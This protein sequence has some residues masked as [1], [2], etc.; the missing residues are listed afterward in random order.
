MNITISGASGL[1][2]RRLM[3]TLGAAG[4]SLTVL[5]RHAGMNM[6]AGVRLLAWD[7][8][9]G[10]PPAESLREAD[11]VVHLAGEPVAQHWTEDSKRRIRE[12]RVAGTR[13]LVEALAKLEQRPQTLVSSSAVGY[14]GSRGDEILTESSSP[15]SGFLADVCRAWETEAFAAEQLGMRV[16]CIRTGVLLDLRGGALA[17]MLTPFRL[18]A[19]G[20]IGGGRQWMS[21]IHAQDLADL[22]R[23]A[24]ENSVRGSLNGTAPHPVFN[25]DFT[26]ALASALRRPAVLPVP[27]F[28]L[29]LLFGEMSS[30]LLASQRALPRAAEDAG[31]KFRF[32]ELPG[33]LADLL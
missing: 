32:P 17:R 16:V 8:S 11:A 29:R 24:V 15:G 4:H 33:A 19:G 30:V 25:A 3:K 1:I 26:R 5:S 21:W 27:A 6:P 9:R 18:G 10:Q 13:S 7:P 22:Y 2:G 20:P 14:Y 23:F 12:S 28:A 31:F